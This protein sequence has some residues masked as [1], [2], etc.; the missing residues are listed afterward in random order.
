MARSKQHERLKTKEAGKSGKKEVALS[1]GK[2]LDVKKKDTAI[3]IERSGNTDKA[4]QRLKTS[5]AP[6]NKLIVPQ[7]D[8]DKAAESMK[9]RRSKPL[10]FRLSLSI[11][12]VKTS[13]FLHAPIVF[14]ISSLIIF[15]KRTV[16]P[17][18]GAIDKSVLYRIVMYIIDMLPIIILVSDF[19]IPKT[20]LPDPAGFQL[21]SRPV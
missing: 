16:L 19:M 8:M 20:I 6:K 10:W 7:K 18:S 2:R 13:G 5:K 3:E 17:I 4:A 12:S 15:H 11:R 21:P 14:I 1:G 9:P